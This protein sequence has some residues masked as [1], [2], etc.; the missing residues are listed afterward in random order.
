M[1]NEKID[2]RGTNSAKWEEAVEAVHSEEVIPLSVAEMD[3]EVPDQ[4]KTK[5]KTATAH[6]IYGYT[7]VSESYEYIVQQ[8]M[9]NS[10]G[11]DIKQDWV[12]FCPR[13][14]QA[15]SLVIQNFT[16]EQDKI[17]I[18]TPLYGP[19]R[20]AIE[21]NGRKVIENPLVLKGN[22]YELDVTDLEKQL[23]SGVKMM[24]LCS[25]HNPTG[26]VYTE[27][28]LQTIANLCKRYN[29]LL[30][31]DEVHADFTFNGVHVSAGSIPEIREQVI[32]CTSPAKTFNLPGL[33]AA[34]IIVPSESIRER[35]KECLVKNGFL[36]PNYFAVPAL[37][38]AYTL[39]DDWLREVK[40]Y[41]QKN[42]QFAENY[43]A[44][45]FPFL[46]I[47]P[48]EGTFLMWIDGTGSG[49]SEAALERWFFEEAK[50]AVSMGSSF[51]E[52]GEGFIR[53]NIA[54]P[55]GQLEEAF[56]RLQ[57]ANPCKFEG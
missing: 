17:L 44:E 23:A 48:S 57:A 24:I 15:V 10:Y 30:V 25:P 43:F 49:L 21:M 5:L 11:W 8:W 27:D 12:V 41:I 42:R 7:N 46:N 32:V 9:K 2:R 19:L 13:I 40:A 31:S 39:C 22:H 37:E 52:A 20:Q 47:I 54:T 36:N 55:M 16:A 33:E 26:K 1:F 45:H 53:M 6:G 34:N 28:E 14:I 3:F 38:A 4:I 35:F 56:E 29:V 51:G 50:V 18:Q